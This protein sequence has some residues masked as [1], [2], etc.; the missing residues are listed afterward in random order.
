MAEVFKWRT[1]I[2][3]TPTGEFRHR[4]KEVEFGDGYK[5]VSGDG[6][7]TE[8]QSWPFTYTGQKTEVMPI[9]AFIRRHATKSFVWTPPFGEKGLYRVKA[10]SITLK[11]IG[12]S[13]I[14]I[15]ATFEQAFSA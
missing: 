11:P 4:I 1:Q 12:G 7:N 9:F 2:Q 3:E 6:I 14:T 13:M 8:S 10:D 5:Q 15:T